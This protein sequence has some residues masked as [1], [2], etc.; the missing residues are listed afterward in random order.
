MYCHTIYTLSW[1]F[2][3]ETLMVQYDT[4]SSYLMSTI[5][6]EKNIEIISKIYFHLQISTQNNWSKWISLHI[7]CLSYLQQFSYVKNDEE[8]C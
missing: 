5:N 7:K 3:I 2:V 8:F 4:D 1:V 6:K